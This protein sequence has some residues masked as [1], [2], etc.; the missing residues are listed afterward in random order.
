M[1]NDI[2]SIHWLRQRDLACRVRF[3]ERQMAW[4][5]STVTPRQTSQPSLPRS[6]EQIGKITKLLGLLYGLVRVLLVF[7]PW[8]LVGLQT[9]WKYILPYLGRLAA[10]G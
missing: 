6:M 1:R 3:L 10:G 9:V 8:V 4:L 2:D 5:V 7:G